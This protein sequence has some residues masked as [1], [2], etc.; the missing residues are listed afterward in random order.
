MTDIKI[1]LDVEEIA[2]EVALDLADGSYV[3]LGIGLPQKVAR[4]IPVGREVVF[5][6]EN[7]ILGVGPEAPSGQEDWDLID[8]GKRP[9]TLLAGGSYIHHTDSF[10]IV[11]GGHLDA[12]VLGAFEVS[13][14]GDIA[15]WW[16]G[17][18]IPA[19]G[20]A[21]D[22]CQGAK[23]VIVIMRHTTAEG[24]PK[25][26][27]ACTMPL[28]AAGVVNRIYTDLGIFTPVGDSVIVNALARG[29]TRDYVAARTGVPVAVPDAGAP[30]ALPRK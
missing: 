16:T 14:R 25:I 30:L 7:G 21:M 2:R 22:L 10:V 9:V 6:S 20:G 26:V 12:C 3:N 5:H 13:T 17:Q 23:S 15:N 11:R 28:S 27:P 18:G 4:Y 19:V 8:A 29:M 24:G 1:G